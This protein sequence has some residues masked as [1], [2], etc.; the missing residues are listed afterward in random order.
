LISVGLIISV[1]GA[2]LAWTLMSSEVLYTAAA[3]E[4]APRFLAHVN[5]HGVPSRALLF[6]TGLIQLLLIV[7]LFSEDAFTFMLELCS[8]LSLV[9][10]LLTAAFA[11]RL[12]FNRE[13]YP[14]GSPGRVG[15]RIIASLATLYTLF[16]LVAAGFGL[17]L[18]SCLIYAPA[19]ILY[20]VARRERRLRVFRK[21]EAV[22]CVVAVAGAV[23][24]IVGLATRLIVI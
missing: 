21:P 18:L 15:A 16:L 17:L 4:D 20:V 3:N 2:Y 6:S 24:G 13:E 7:T 23:V 14:P 19:T 11:V 1:L 9:P 10:Y 8:A 12:A 22:L 5:A